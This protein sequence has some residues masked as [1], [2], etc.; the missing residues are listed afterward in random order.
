MS[1]EILQSKIVKITELTSRFCKEKL[2]DDYQR[3]ITELIGKLSRKRP[4]PLLRGKEEIWSA[5]IIH[6]L[7][8][9][10][11]LYDNSFEPYITLDDLNT[12]FGTKKSTV[13]SK[14]QEIRKMFRMDSITNSE[15]MINKLKEESP[16]M[17][18][19]MVDGFLVPLSTLPVE[20]QQKVKEAREQGK[21][22][23]FW[24]S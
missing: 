15:F 18:A 11:F 7:G 20:Y 4:S 22:I 9:V 12:D 10:N 24:S 21:D 16:I 17:N 2:D 3:L 8:Q 23:Q 1:K 5:A 6:S 14:A 19:V 13:G